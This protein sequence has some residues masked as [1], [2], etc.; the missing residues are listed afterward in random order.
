I[1]GKKI[2]AYKVSEATGETAV[3]QLYFRILESKSAI[4]VRLENG[5][6]TVAVTIGVKADLRKYYGHEGADFL[7]GEALDHIEEK[8]AESVRGDVEAA[9]KR[10]QGDLRTD[11]FGFGFALYRKYPRV[12]KE[13]FLEQ[14]RDIFPDIPV[15]VQINAKVV[16]VGITTRKLYI[17]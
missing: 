7:F 11:I 8:L 6:P 14:W 13:E 4:K 15:T 5:R 1:R 10:G 9:L 17:K 16:N 2:H 12:W 3:D